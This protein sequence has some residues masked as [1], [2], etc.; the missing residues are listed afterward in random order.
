MVLKSQPP[1]RIQEGA[2]SKAAAFSQSAEAPKELPFSFNK[3]LLALLVR[4]PF[5]AYGYW[6]FSGDTWNWIENLRRKDSRTKP[7]LRIHNIDRGG[8]LDLD[9][10]LEAKNWYI[11]LGIPD[12]TF[13]A[14]LGL[15]DSQGRFHL[16]A[17]SNRIK[18]PRNAP[19]T[20]IDP[21]WSLTPE[22]FEEIYKLS[23]GGKTGSGSEFFS[24]VKRR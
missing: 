18:T 3:T 21:E 9:V 7:K 10:Q 16:I 20:K 2:P 14:E 15:I 5:W 11:E 4:D 8:S 6:D 17:K 12:C 23:G 13:E 19:S 1:R 22:E 24:Q